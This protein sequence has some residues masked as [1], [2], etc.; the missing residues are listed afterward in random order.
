M[1]R[2][3]IRNKENERVCDVILYK[4]S[5]KVTLVTKEGRQ[6]RYIDYDQLQDQIETLKTTTE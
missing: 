1:V 5:S 6:T 4:E 3:P 2:R